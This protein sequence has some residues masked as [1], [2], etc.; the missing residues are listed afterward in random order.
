MKPGFAIALLVVAAASLWCRPSRA[1]DDSASAAGPPA[2]AGEISLDARPSAASAP[3]LPDL[4]AQARLQ[5]AGHVVLAAAF[6][7]VVVGVV[8]IEVDPYML[9]VGDWGFGAVGVGVSALI[10]SSFILGLT[11]PVHLR[12]HPS[13]R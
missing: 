11:R 6:A 12:D 13:Q 8:L 1:A 7:F 9:K 2:P 10:T 3:E 5:L 4:V